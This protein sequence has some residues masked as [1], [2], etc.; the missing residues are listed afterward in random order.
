MVGAL[1]LV[2]MLFF[3]KCHVYIS[4]WE[5]FLL[6]QPM[7]ICRGVSVLSL[8]RKA[9]VECEQITYQLS[10]RVFCCEAGGVWMCSA[11]LV[12]LQYIPPRLNRTPL[13]INFPNKAGRFIWE[14]KDSI[15]D[16]TCGQLEVWVETQS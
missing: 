16:D 2:N 15:P 1:L 9:L 4:S 13:M 10:Q 8:D 6:G 11:M 5:T 3:E 7:S 12:R 14:H